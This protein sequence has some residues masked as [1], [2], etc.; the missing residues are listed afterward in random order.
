[1]HKGSFKV[2]IVSFLLFMGLVVL[3]QTVARGEIDSDQ[4]LA[5]LKYEAFVNDRAGVLSTNDR[6]ALNQKLSVFKASTSNE[7]VVVLLSSLQG[8]Q[9]DDFANKL[10][11][12]WKLGEAGKDNGLLLLAAIED[13]KMRIEVGYGLEGVLPDA[14]CGRI[15]DEYITPAF[16]E[17]LYAKG[18]NDGVDAMIA[19]IVRAGSDGQAAPATE[20]T[21]ASGFQALGF[22]IIMVLEVVILIVLGKKYGKSSGTSQS[23]GRSGSSSSSSSSSGGSG[24]GGRSGGGGASGSW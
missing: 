9:I 15:R 6:Q 21:A 10:F 24:G 7:M 13:R 20:A 1:M 2:G 12:K 8:G 19:V 11:A 16:K 17:K 5:S 14:A 4:L 22:L 3:F 18:L 23:G